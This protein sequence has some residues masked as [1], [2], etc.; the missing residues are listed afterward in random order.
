[1]TSIIT[2]NIQC[3]LG[4]DGQHNLTRIADN[5]RA[6][7]DADV[8]C[9]QEVSRFMTELDAGKGDDQVEILTELFPGYQ[10]FFGA[11]INQ[12]DNH[13]PDRRQFG[14]LILSRLPV[15]QAFFH[16][17]PQPHDAGLKHMPRQLTEVVV[18][19]ATGP[20]RILTTHLEY[21]SSIQRMAQVNAIHEL[22]SQVCDNIRWP[23]LSPASGPYNHIARPETTVICGDFN[24]TPD[25]TEHKKLL[26]GFRYET[27]LLQDAWRVQNNDKP[28]APTCGIF[29]KHQWPE[30]AHA[31]DFF[32]I[33]ADLS[34]KIN[35]L[36]I[37]VKT[38]ASDH[39][40][41]LL[42]LNY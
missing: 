11:A 37:N 34:G 41:L 12:S 31:R 30:G 26:S 36:N 14:N 5:I 18:E 20:M 9:L 35:N 16:P 29:D 13:N 39:Q 2:W 4:C 38:D 21:H 3:G 24:F 19:C 1:M 8:I 23:G 33:T 15:L 27:A 22:H 17:L 7:G 32:F 28:H 25:S 40:P 42:D 10:T 6:T